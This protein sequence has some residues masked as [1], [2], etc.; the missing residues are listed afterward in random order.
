MTTPPVVASILQQEV[1]FFSVRF[2][3]YCP[4]SLQGLFAIR[5]ALGFVNGLRPRT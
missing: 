4:K 5:F 3:G 2:L 1:L